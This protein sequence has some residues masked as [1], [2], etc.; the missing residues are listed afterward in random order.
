MWEG[1]TG[2]SSPSKSTRY[3]LAQK[4]LHG[5]SRSKHRPSAVK[6][7]AAMSEPYLEVATNS[8][9]QGG[10][11][12]ENLI[13]R[14]G[15]PQRERHVRPSMLQGRCGCT[16]VV[17]KVRPLERGQTQSPVRQVRSIETIW[18]GATEAD[19]SSRWDC[20]QSERKARPR[21][22]LRQA[23]APH[24]GTEGGSALAS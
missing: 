2:E 3:N 21:I 24:F 16:N 11:D 10:C 12:R 13:R 1:A 6:R 17:R 4:A 7:E 18:E 14:R 19:L 9:E 8:H 22:S 5:M 15:Q 20:V 23:R